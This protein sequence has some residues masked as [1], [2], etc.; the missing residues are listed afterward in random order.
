M[1]LPN[2]SHL[3]TVSEMSLMSFYIK[4]CAVPTISS[5]N[6]PL[7]SNPV[8]EFSLVYCFKASLLDLHIHM[9]FI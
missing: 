8:G 1:S 2:L 3:V 4:P 5:L 7:V 9:N 6:D